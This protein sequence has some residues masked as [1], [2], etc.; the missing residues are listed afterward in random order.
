MRGFVTVAATREEAMGRSA[1]AWSQRGLSNPKDHLMLA[2]TNAEVNSLNDMAQKTRLA[3]GELG[4][5]SV[6]VRDEKIHENDRVLFTENKKQL[7]VINSEFGTVTAV[8]PR[9]MRLTVQVDGADQPV[10]FSLAQFD[11]LKRGYAATVHRAQGMTLDQDAYVLFGG[12]MQSREMTYVQI[13]RARGNTFLFTDKATTAQ[14][15]DIERQAGRS[16]EKTAAHTVSREAQ[17]P[18][19]SQELHLSETTP[20]AR[21]STTPAHR[22]DECRAAGP[23]F[24][25]GETR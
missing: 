24:R 22:G 12:T 6:T 4:W 19:L 14:L 1:P 13:S 10:T 2:S 9:R 21:P 17:K 8:D 11:G 25:E 18:S 5:K 23:V 16:V 15:G 20:L 7:G 3:A